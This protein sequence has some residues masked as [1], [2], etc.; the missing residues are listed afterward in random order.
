MNQGKEALEVIGKIKTTKKAEKA[1]A[2]LISGWAKRQMG[3]LDTAEKFLL[4]ST[5]LNPQSSRAFFELGQVHQAKGEVEKAMK[6]YYSA[7]SQVFSEKT[8]TNLSHQ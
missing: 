2:L 4:Q 1:R 5:K 6:A 7:L 3:E 8:D